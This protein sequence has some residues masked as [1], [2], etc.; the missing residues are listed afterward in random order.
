MFALG[1]NIIH[2]KAHMWFWGLS[3]ATLVGGEK[4]QKGTLD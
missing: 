2:P 1:G 3:S 4:D